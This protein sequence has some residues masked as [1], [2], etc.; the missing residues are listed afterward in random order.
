MPY[1]TNTT[2]PE[3][4]T[5]YTPFIEGKTIFI[6]GVS[7]RSLGDFYSQ[8][9]AK[10]KPASLILADRNPVN[11]SNVLEKSA[12]TTPLSRSKHPTRN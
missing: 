1:D 12:P 6:T 3:L 5:D 7:P 10:A 11:L 2:A 9:I 4:V 8:S